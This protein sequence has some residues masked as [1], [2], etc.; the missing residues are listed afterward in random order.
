MPTIVKK[1]RIVF[2]S[3][4]IVTSALLLV[5][6]LTSIE[7]NNNFILFFL[8]FTVLGNLSLII[9]QYLF[10]K[11]SKKYVVFLLLTVFSACFAI[12]VLTWADNWKTQ[13]IF[14][15]N[16]KH[17]RQTIE[18]RMRSKYGYGFEKQIVRKKR[19]LPFIDDIIIAD[20]AKIDKSKWIRVNEI[21]NEMG[22]PGDYII[23]K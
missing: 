8:V 16:A 3:V 15:R 2:I 20:T 10:D 14:Y 12:A 22:F 13:A 21:V 7:I 4:L 23:A 11:L 6:R 18:Y 9:S 1:E 5:E 19:I 17:T